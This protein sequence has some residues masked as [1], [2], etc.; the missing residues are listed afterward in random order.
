MW[1]WVPYEE[2]L[3]Q[4]KDRPVLVLAEEEAARGGRDGSGEVLIAL[5]MTT[6]DRVATGEVR[7]DRHG[8][9]WIDIGSGSWD[10]QGRDSEVRADRLLRIPPAALRRDGAR[11]PEQRFVRVA[12][13]VGEVHGWD[14]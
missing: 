2:D 9:T 12:A 5:M 7:T 11:L 1:A 6:R 13:V 4:G 3:S 14:G 10:G 8:S